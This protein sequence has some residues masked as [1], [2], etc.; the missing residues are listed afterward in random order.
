MV[1]ACKVV[2]P[3]PRGGD[4]HAVR[5]ERM[6]IFLSLCAENGSIFDGV[7]SARGGDRAGSLIFFI[8][9]LEFLFTPDLARLS[10]HFRLSFSTSVE[11]KETQELFQFI[12]FSPN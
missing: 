9:E 1:L 10:S 2:A 3:F 12:Q 4:A 8:K 11:F 5:S 7:C 6:N